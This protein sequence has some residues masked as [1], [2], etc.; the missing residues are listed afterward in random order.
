[1]AGAWEIVPARLR[2][3]LIFRFENG[4]SGSYRL[5]RTDQETYLDEQRYFVLPNDRCR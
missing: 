5:S 4:K 1:V 2:V 3:D